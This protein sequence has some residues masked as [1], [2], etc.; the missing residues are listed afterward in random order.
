V[1]TGITERLVEDG[2]HVEVPDTWVPLWGDQFTTRDADPAAVVYVVDAGRP[3]TQLPP[4]AR[5]VASAPGVDVYVAPG[6]AAR[7][8]AQ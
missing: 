1:A 6:T 7:A 2:R 3:V 4:L 8:P 5:H